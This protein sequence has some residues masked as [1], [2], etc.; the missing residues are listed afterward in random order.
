M[1]IILTFVRHF[2]PG[3]KSGGPVRTIANL[4]DHLGGEFEFRVVTSDRDMLDKKPYFG[5]AVDEWNRVGKAWV[6]Y[7]SM[8]NHSISNWIRLI[9]KTRHDVIYLNSFFDVYFT[10]YPLV[11]N[12][13]LWLR[14]KQMIV[15]PRGEF[16]HGAL[17]IK[18]FKKIPYIVMARLLG[19]F[20]NVL[21]VAS[22][23]QESIDIR[24]WFGGYAKIMVARDM[25][26]HK[27]ND[28]ALHH[29]IGSTRT[30][31]IVFMSRICRKKN[32]DYAL[33]VLTQVQQQIQFDIYGTIEDNSYWSKCQ[34]LI[35]KMPANIEVNY[36]GVA[37]NAKVLEIISAYD[38]FFLP[39]WGENYGHAI[40]EALTAGTPVLLSD[41]TPWRNLQ[42][43]GV[44]W[45][46]S[47]EL[48][49][50][51]FASVIEAAA[52]T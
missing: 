48:G 31:R 28:L 26:P 14:S 10:F 52:K 4:I 21:W 2:L 41:K 42:E 17:K 33:K 46:L 51:V 22:T 9:K 3:F 27:K 20:R 1:K 23:E 6:Y 40:A 35:T 5:V 47:L 12:K 32:L 7:A 44:G 34:K 11:A 50:N 43:Y 39:T 36:R 37:D 19:L 29:V 24:R 30:L 16:S 45:D 25:P 8:Q 49:E 15:A 38:I 13:I 18:R